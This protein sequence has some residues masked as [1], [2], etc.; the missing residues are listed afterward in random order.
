MSENLVKIV[1][2]GNYTNLAF[3]YYIN[4]DADVKECIKSEQMEFG[5]KFVNVNGVNTDEPVVTLVKRMGSFVKPVD[6][7]IVE[8]ITGDI[9]SKRIK[10]SLLDFSKANFETPNNISPPD[11]IYDGS[12]FDIK[13]LEKFSITELTF[14]IQYAESVKSSKVLKA[15]MLYNKMQK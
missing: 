15:N 9:N 3:P 6:S 1:K 5:I 8:L 14:V 11:P 10:G 2:T 7:N 4:V 12:G 13:Q